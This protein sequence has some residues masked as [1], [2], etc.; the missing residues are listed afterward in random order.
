MTDAR[1]ANQLGGGYNIVYWTTSECFMGG[2]QPPTAELGKFATSEEG[3]LGK[4]ATSE[5]GW[6]GRIVRTPMEKRGLRLNEVSTKMYATRW[7]ASASSF[8]ACDRAR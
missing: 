6:L 1:S 8:R 2:V 5:E 7:G 4:F 3:W